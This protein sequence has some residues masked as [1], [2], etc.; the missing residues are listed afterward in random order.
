[1]SDKPREMGSAAL[2]GV[3]G[4]LAMTGMRQFAAELGLIGTTPPEELAEK[5]DAVSDTPVPEDKGRA[6]V[7]ALH[8][9]VGAAGGV[10][11]GMLPDS[12]RQQ[13]W[14][15]PAWGLVIWLGYELAVEPLL[16]LGPVERD[17]PSEH[18]AIVADHLV[19]G[20]VISETRGQ[21]R[22]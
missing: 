13:P 1:M 18:A 6:A 16:G 19:Y 7:L 21:P 3:V 15:G 14:G 11:F 9:A 8:C 20:Y 5:A 12:I 10:G 22:G 17:K 4:A 2:R